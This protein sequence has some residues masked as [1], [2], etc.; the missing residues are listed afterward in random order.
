MANSDTNR[1][2]PQQVVF[3]D[4]SVP[5]LQSLLD[6]LLPG[7]I[8]FVLDHTSDGIRQIADILSANNLTDLSS[9]DIVGHGTSGAVDLGSTVLDDADLSEHAGALAQIGAA[10]V[11]G[12]NLKLYSCDAASGTSGQ[13]FIADLSHLVGVNVTASTSA[14]GATATGENWALN[15]TAAPDGDVGSVPADL[16]TSPFTTAVEASFAGTLG[17]SASDPEIW[18]VGNHVGGTANELARVDDALGDG[19]AS[20]FVDLFDPNNRNPSSNP[21]DPLTNLDIVAFDTAHNEYF[22]AGSNASNEDNIYRASI[23][24]TDPGTVTPTLTEIFHIGGPTPIGSITG[25]AVDPASQEIFFTNRQSLYKM[26]ENVSGIQTLASPTVTKLGD[27]SNLATFHDNNGNAIFLD[28]LALDLPRHVAYFS[29]STTFSTSDTQGNPILSVASN[30]IYKGTLDA[31]AT[32]VT[33]SKLV[34][35]NPATMGVVSNGVVQNTVAVDSQGNFYFTTTDDALINDGGIFEIDAGTSTIHTIWQQNQPGSGPMS[36][37]SAIVTDS[38]TGKYY[39]TEDNFSASGTNDN[40]IYVGNLSDRNVAPTLFEVIPAYAAGA[41]MVPLGM[42]IDNAP[43]LSVTSANASYSET[44]GQPSADGTPVT[45]LSTSTLTDSDNSI[46]ASGSVSITTGFDSGVDK[47]TINGLASG[48]LGSI[49]FSYNA[50]TGVMS[51]SG[52]DTVANYNTALDDVK[53]VASGD[54]PTNYGT[55]TSRTVSYVV[56]DGL[57]SSAAVTSTVSVTGVN[58]APKNTLPGAQSVNED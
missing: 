53:F 36:Q 20:N 19:H 37:I 24:Q 35:V 4:S 6:G 16:A 25:L 56:S 33:I 11:P 5:E 23:S 22:L 10:L 49:T 26:S 44:A 18:V 13:Q 50:A 58:D 55:D 12:G 32:S 28:G 8:A 54:N 27:V 17:Q 41:Q 9:I 47:L 30:A 42:A 40:A 39:V 31:N 1:T 2:A 14:I 45:P 7:E 46:L 15:V 43:V 38:Q 3:V 29:E 34:D 21:T 48:S 57:L 51:L 52:V